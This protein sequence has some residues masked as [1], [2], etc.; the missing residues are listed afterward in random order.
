MEEVEEP[1]VELGWEEKQN[2]DDISGIETVR[3]SGRQ[4]AKPKRL[5]EEEGNSDEH[6]PIE[7]GMALRLRKRKRE[8]ASSNRRFGEENGQTADVRRG[9]RKRAR[10]IRFIEEEDDDDEGAKPMNGDAGWGQINQKQET[11]GEGL[12]RTLGNMKITI[13][14]PSLPEPS[15]NQQA[16][17]EE[18]F[19]SDFTPV[20]R[21]GRLRLRKLSTERRQDDESSGEGDA[22]IGEEEIKLNGAEE[23]SDE[24]KESAEEAEQDDDPGEE[25]GLGG[26][27]SLQE[28]SAPTRGVQTRRS[29]RK[30]GYSPGTNTITVGLEEDGEEDDD[31]SY[32][33]TR[34]RR[35]GKRYAPSGG[36]VLQIG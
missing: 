28:H 27:E 21:S 23:E 12:V 29:A 7:E 17:D 31:E 36:Q 35:K 6:S 13:K 22:D 34:R 16:E 15:A 24:W 5:C 33:I 2:G 18:L 3:R 9:N 32:V 14:P 8:Q 19:G 11:H 30:L 20:R 10:P 25:W 26:L 1:A 4:R